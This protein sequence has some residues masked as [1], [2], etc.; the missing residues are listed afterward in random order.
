MN[1]LDQ[2]C[3][4]ITIDMSTVTPDVE[5]MQMRED[6]EYDAFITL[7]TKD[8]VAHYKFGH[9][10][11]KDGQLAILLAHLYGDEMFEAIC[12]MM[13]LKLDLGNSI[14]ES[15]NIILDS[16]LS[17]EPIA[18]IQPATFGHGHPE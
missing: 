14:V 8:N 5:D 3:T 18:I 10:D 11:D 9:K 6:S 17:E 16:T 7:Y 4:E 12:K 13:P 1:Y 2:F 15:A